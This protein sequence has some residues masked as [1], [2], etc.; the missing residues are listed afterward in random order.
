MP[1]SWLLGHCSQNSVLGTFCVK[2]G[3]HLLKRFLKVAFSF[4]YTLIPKK[5]QGLSL[6]KMWHKNII[7]MDIDNKN[8]QRTRRALGSN[9]ANP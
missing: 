1:D 5:T 8:P 9:Q 6:K 3:T 2:Q 4:N 7:K